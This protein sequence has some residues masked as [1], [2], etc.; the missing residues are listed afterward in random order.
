MRG[1][2]AYLLAVV[3]SSEPAK[4]MNAAVGAQCCCPCNPRL[5]R[6]GSIQLDVARGRPAVVLVVRRTVHQYVMPA[7]P[8]NGAP[9]R[10]PGST[11]EELLLITSPLSHT[12]PA[13]VAAAAEARS[14]AMTSLYV[15]CVELR[16]CSDPSDSIMLHENLGCSVSI[17]IATLGNRPS[18]SPATGTIAAGSFSSQFE[19][20]A[21]VGTATQR[22]NVKRLAQVAI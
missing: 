9:S 8:V 17:P 15:A 10:Q 21:A 22:N 20:A 4:P 6:R 13:P 14:V 7:V 11:K 19:A 3:L 16:S 18:T 2:R 12:T 5:N 1:L